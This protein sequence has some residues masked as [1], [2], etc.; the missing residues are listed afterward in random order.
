MQ[1][2]TDERFDSLIRELSS[3]R[4]YTD[5]LFERVA[6]A[7]I[8]ERP[9]PERHRIA[10]YVGHL[11]AFDLNLLWRE[12]NGQRSLS[13]LDRLFAFGID[14]A[15]GALPT[16][17]A[18]DWPA[19]A[20][21]REYV[22]QARARL[23]RWLSDSPSKL[24]D[25]V[26]LDTLLNAA[27]EH[28][29]M[30]AETLAYMLNRLPIA[31]PLRVVPVHRREFGDDMVSIPAGVATLGMQIEDEAF[32]WDNEYQAHQVEVAAFE[33]DRYMVTNA[34]FLRFIEAGG[35]AES[36]WWRADDWQW[37][38]SRKIFHPAAWRRA[39][40]EWRQLSIVDEVPLQDD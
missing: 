14:P 11:D 20:E 9:I 17:V 35:Y 7:L 15:D 5:R 16:D 12:R 37:L 3:A 38:Q 8:Y 26:P 31:K 22:K 6:Q 40:G 23:D 28:R 29:L 36:R 2:R 4:G 27:I 19:L 10:F 13:A 34:Q 1:R 33:I 30:H 32:G 21:I 18:Q 39:N 25:D 24:V